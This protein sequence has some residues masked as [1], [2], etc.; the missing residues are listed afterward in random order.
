VRWLVLAVV[1]AGCDTSIAGY[2][3][4]YERGAATYVECSMS[5]D[6][7]NSVALDDIGAALDR[8][9]LDET[10]LQL[11]AH[12]PTRTVEAATIEDVI[13]AA[14]DRGMAFATYAQL[15][16]G[17]VPGSLALSFDDHDLAGWT[18]LRP[19]FDRY[20]AKVTFFVSG[21]TTLDDTQKAQLRALADDGHDIEYHSTHHYFADEYTAEH[22]IDAYIDDDIMPGLEAMRADGW[23]PHVFAYPHGARTAE[24]DDALRPLFDHLRAIHFTCPY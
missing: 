4:I 24:T 7:K 5:I 23:D 12:Q 19:I 10:T 8:A 18:T 14:A 15:S 16:D 9:Q 11:Y 20:G 22:G 21:Y 1:L 3:D 13:A 17:E 6:D 2:D